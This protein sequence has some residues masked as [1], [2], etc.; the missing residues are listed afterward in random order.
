MGKPT[1]RSHLDSNHN[2]NITNTDSKSEA[3]YPEESMALAM[4]IVEVK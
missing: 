2:L 1:W 3:T 4:Y